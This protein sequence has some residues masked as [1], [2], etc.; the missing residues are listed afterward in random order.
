MKNGLHSMGF[1]TNFQVI[2]LTHLLNETT[3][4][5]HIKQTP[6]LYSKVIK[7]FGAFMIQSN[8]AITIPNITNPVIMKS[9][10]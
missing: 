10:F 2:N 1:Q 6:L 7:N 4:I 3:I 8:L 5:D 9:R